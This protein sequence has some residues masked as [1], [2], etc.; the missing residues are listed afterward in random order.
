[1]NLLNS[2]Q[3]TKSLKKYLRG[4]I[5]NRLLLRGKSRNLRIARNVEI[6]GDIIIGSN[7][8]I[9]SNV[10]IYKKS[11]ISDN[12]YLGDSVELRSNAGNKIILGEGCTINRGSLIM[13]EVEIGENCL[14]APLC[15]IVGSNHNFDST[16]EL[17]NSQGISSKGIVI[18]HNVWL[19][20]Q[21]IV[22]DGVS[23]GANS[24]IGAGSVVTKNIPS[25]S[26]AVG[27]PCKVIKS[28]E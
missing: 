14:I 5:F 8:N 25:N 28:R 1:M 27:N 7:V 22:L 21:V 24:I 20:A 15:V 10:K 26:I 18:E 23:I 3:K 11:K 13:G 6:W 12:V 9:G 16:S 4:V 17:I 19:G 2:Y